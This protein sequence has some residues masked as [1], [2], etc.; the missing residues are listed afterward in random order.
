MVLGRGELGS[1]LLGLASKITRWPMLRMSG[2]GREV[3]ISA[4]GDHCTVRMNVFTK[5][6]IKP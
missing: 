1:L 4:L 6:R 5:E 2:S 3:E